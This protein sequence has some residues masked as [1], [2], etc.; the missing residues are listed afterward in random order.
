MLKYF[1]TLAVPNMIH[2]L[3]L[4]LQFLE[5]A[6]KIGISIQNKHQNLCAE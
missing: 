4:M 5:T 2:I 3:N 1:V 6:I